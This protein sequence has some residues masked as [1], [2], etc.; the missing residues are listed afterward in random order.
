M[1]VKDVLMRLYLDN[2]KAYMVKI[3]TNE[4]D[5]AGYY[6]MFHG[7]TTNAIKSNFSAFAMSLCFDND[8][9]RMLSNLLDWKVVE[10]T[11]EKSDIFE[12]HTIV[13]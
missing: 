4:G 8:E 2:G 5:N 3:V 1:N 11:S 12:S 10:H 6:T 9:A 13:I 7:Y